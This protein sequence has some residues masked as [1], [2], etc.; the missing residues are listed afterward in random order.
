MVH[1]KKNINKRIFLIS[2]FKRKEKKISDEQPNNDK[3]S[4]VVYK[5]RI[6]SFIK[7]KLKKSDDCLTLKPVGHW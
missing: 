2:L 5:I 6:T 3:Y 4:V 7:A 1:Y